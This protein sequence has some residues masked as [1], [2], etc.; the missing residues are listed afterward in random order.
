MTM[1]IA[2]DMELT[3]EQGQQ[4]VR[5][6]AELVTATV[7]GRKPAT[8]ETELGELAA[9]SCAGTF[10]SLKRRGHLRSCC[11]SF[12]RTMPLL[13]SLEQSARRTATSDPRF[14]PVSASEL[15]YL[16]VEVWLLH[17]PEEVGETVE[18]RISAVTV[19]RH[20]LQIVSGEARG[21]LLPG[22]PVEHGWDAE[23]FLNQVCIKAGL[24]PT[25]WKDGGTTLYRFGGDAFRGP[26]VDGGAQPPAAEPRSLYTAREFAMIAQHGRATLDALLRG[27]TPLYYCPSVSDANVNGVAV[28]VTSQASGRTLSATRHSLRQTVPLQST[29]FGLCESLAGSIS[30][31]DFRPGTFEVDVAIL[32]DTALHGSVAAP[33]LDGFDPQRRGLV[34]AERARSALVFDRHAVPGALF[35]Q[36]LQLARVNEPEAAQIFSVAVQSTQNPLTLVAGAQPVRGADVRPPG[37]A[38]MFYPAD[39]DE[40]QHQL[41]ELLAGE[42]P[43]GRWRAALVPHAGWKFSGRI[44]ADVLKRIELPRTIIAIGPKHTPHGVEWSVAPHRT[45]ALPGG[46][47]ESDPELAR[48]LAAAIEGLELDAAAH[49]QEHGVEVELPILK[50]L[51]PESRVVGIAIGGGN[52]ERC[53]QFAAGL[54]SVIARLEEPPLLLISSDMN[55]FAT[56]SENRRLDALAL[57]ELDRLDADALYHTTRKHHISMCGMLPAVIVLKTLEKLGALSAAERVGYATSAD[58]SGDRSRV[59]GYAGMLF[60]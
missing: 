58:V 14:P 8:A 60:R 26:L 45:W 15:D 18:A 37:V 56:D 57:A 21:L 53:E 2:T 39:A 19:G 3:S 22:V 52:L 16:D 46:S 32:S 25:A 47:V 6:A 27:A 11:G 43:R 40:V 10:V 34:I 42:A 23:E 7:L 28:T 33:D 20:G 38:G 36:A 55:H 31:Q 1:P 59:V 17:A 4:L 30:G 54:A 29:L 12:G 51:S 24:T 48:A 41:D 50:R 13:E 49:R 5:A 9:R 44:A 35:E